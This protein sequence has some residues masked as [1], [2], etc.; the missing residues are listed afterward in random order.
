[1][2]FK[3]NSLSFLIVALSVC[4]VPLVCSQDHNE[5]SFLAKPVTLVFP[6]SFPVVESGDGSRESPLIIKGAQT[7]AALKSVLFNWLGVNQT[8]RYYLIEV[9]DPYRADGVLCQKFDFA[10]TRDGNDIRHVYTKVLGVDSLADHRY[11]FTREDG[12]VITGI[13]YRDNGSDRLKGDYEAQSGIY[14]QQSENFIGFDLIKVDV[15]P[16][17]ELG[18]HLIRVRVRDGVQSKDREVWQRPNAA[19]M[20]PTGT[21]NKLILPSPVG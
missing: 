18:G 16:V 7:C 13:P 19:G 20:K 2:T 10:R 15:F 11:L 3:R 1:M 12:Q 9:G 21:D 5:K 8:N 17:G 6:W 4:V 14:V